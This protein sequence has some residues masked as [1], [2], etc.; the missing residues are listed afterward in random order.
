VLSVG[1]IGYT[2]ILWKQ[3]IQNGD[4]RYVLEGFIAHAFW[5]ISAVLMAMPFWV[6]WRAWR[7]SRIRAL[8]ELIQMPAP[9]LASLEARLSALR[10]LRPVGAWNLAA[11]VATVASALAAP[12][13][14]LIF[15]L[16]HLT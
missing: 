15:K 6:M 9:E 3:V 11:F 16:A 8:G 1:F 14:Q 10:E 13:I 7:L 12:A 2:A 4:L 5:F